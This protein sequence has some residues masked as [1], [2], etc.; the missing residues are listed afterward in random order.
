LGR[1]TELA[2]DERGARYSVDLLDTAY[3]R[4][5]LPALDAGLFGA[6]FRFRPLK[7]DIIDKP[8]PSSLNLEGLREGHDHRGRR[9]RARASHLPGL[10]QCNR[11]P[12]DRGD[13]R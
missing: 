7:A 1:I 3:T 5:L 2:E 10:C 13:H 4:E 6:S 9:E 12:A 11:R 8:K